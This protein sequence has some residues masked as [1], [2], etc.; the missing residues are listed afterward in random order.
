MNRFEPTDDSYPPDGFSNQEFV[1]FTRRAGCG[2]AS[3]SDNCE[4]E[5]LVG[6]LRH[7]SAGSPKWPYC[8]HH[9]DQR[10]ALG[11]YLAVDH[12]D[13]FETVPVRL[14]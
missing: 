12:R 13:A 1:E 2:G 3:H 9:Y 7:I 14:V 5:K 8:K 11:Y 6:V 4:G 10:Y